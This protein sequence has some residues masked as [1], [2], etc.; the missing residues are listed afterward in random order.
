MI[1]YAPFWNTM[2]AR[3]MTQ[4]RLIKE[5][6]IDCSLLHRLRHDRY[7]TLYTI[8]KLC[9]ILDCRVEE[10]VELADE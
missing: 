2:R 1:S 10:V 6:G 8:E 3:K 7:I 5:H 4:Y 9:R